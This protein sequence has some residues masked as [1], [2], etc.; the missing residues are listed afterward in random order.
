MGVSEK[1]EAG[2][3]N[4]GYNERPTEGEHD[5]RVGGE[6]D[7]RSQLAVGGLKDGLLSRN[8]SEC[9]DGRELVYGLVE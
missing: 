6:G 3:D 4:S 8:R 5:S 9:V 7:K 1:Q 2:E